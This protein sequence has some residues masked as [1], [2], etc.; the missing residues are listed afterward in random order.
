MVHYN[1]VNLINEDHAILFYSLYGLLLNLQ[2]L[3]H[4]SKIACE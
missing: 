3:V 1:L 4:F 2:Q